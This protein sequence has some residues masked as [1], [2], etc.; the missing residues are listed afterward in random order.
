MRSTS[1]LAIRESLGRVYAVAAPQKN[2]LA[3][4]K[5]RGRGLSGHFSD[6]GKWFI[7]VI[8]ELAEGGQ[9]FSAVV[10]STLSWEVTC[11]I[12]MVKNAAGR[13]SRPTAETLKPWRTV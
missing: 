2:L 3:G 6:D 4:T 9:T 7:L 10:V 11:T 1:S 12:P 5:L 8:M 13:S